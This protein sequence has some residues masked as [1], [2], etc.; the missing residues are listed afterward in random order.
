M[1]EIGGAMLFVLGVV[2][3]MVLT[4]LCM[5]MAVGAMKNVF[6]R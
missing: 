3:G 4:V 6:K 2:V 1:I 5:A